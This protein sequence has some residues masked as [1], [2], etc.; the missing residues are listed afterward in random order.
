MM[1]TKTF[2]AMGS[3][4]FIAINSSKEDGDQLLEI[5]SNWF[6]EWERKFSRFDQASE[7][8][9]LNQNQGSWVKV[10]WEMWDVLHLAQKVFLDSHGLVSI[11]MLKELE[12]I[13]YNQD[14]L[15]M[16]KSTNKLNKNSKY[17]KKNILDIEFQFDS[18]SVRIPSRMY[19]DLGGV[20]KGWAA[21]EAMTRLAKNSPALVNAGGDISISAAIQSGN[22]WIIGVTNPDEPEQHLLT[23]TIISGGIATSGKDYRNWQ[24]EGQWLHHILD[25]R[26]GLPAQTD[27]LTATVLAPSVIQAEAAAKT[28]FI[29]GSQA[30]MRWIET[31]PNLAGLMILD[32]RRIIISQRM[33]EYVL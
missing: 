20:V 24:M 12:N 16:Q 10:S 17:T 27:I 8:N 25:P 26:T 30:G 19:F 31:H 21:N 5:S 13:G 1:K 11:T 3:Q 6:A 9:H 28:V 22:P 14:F 32:N 2:R 29:L 7:L 4:V 23:M 33:Q 18:K 15:N